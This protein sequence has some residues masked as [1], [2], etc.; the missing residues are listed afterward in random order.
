MAAL[1]RK[2]SKQLVLNSVFK[3]HASRLKCLSTISNEPHINPYIK[4]HGFNCENAKKSYTFGKIS[5]KS[6]VIFN[7]NKN[8]KYNYLLF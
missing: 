1:L 3:L 2:L 6:A 7:L 5:E 8:I 4:A